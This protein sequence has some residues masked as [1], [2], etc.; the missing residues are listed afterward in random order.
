LSS[1]TLPR[2]VGNHG[3]IWR[4]GASVISMYAVS[5]KNGHSC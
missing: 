3:A 2:W 5:H 1:V 4:Y